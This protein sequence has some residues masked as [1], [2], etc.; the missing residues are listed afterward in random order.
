MDETEDVKKPSEDPSSKCDK[1]T[2][3][4]ICYTQA[5]VETAKGK[6]V[7]VLLLSFIDYYHNPFLDYHSPLGLNFLQDL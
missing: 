1:V 3:R 6:F 7:I 5:T 2:I 4:M